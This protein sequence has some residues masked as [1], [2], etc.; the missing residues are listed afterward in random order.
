MFFIHLGA[1]FLEIL[2]DNSVFL[3]QS[4]DAIIGFTHTTNLT[5]NSVGLESAG[6]SAGGLVNVNDVHLNR[7]VILGSDD[8]VACRAENGFKMII[9][10]FVFK[11]ISLKIQKMLLA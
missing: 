10:S 7:C 4:V 5:T 11:N 6:H 1:Q 9:I 2:G 8:A 3:G